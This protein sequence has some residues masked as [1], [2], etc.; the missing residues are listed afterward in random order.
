MTVCEKNLCCFECVD[1]DI[2]ENVVGDRDG[3]WDVIDISQKIL[4]NLY[5]FVLNRADRLDWPTP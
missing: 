4:L 5:C 3:E 2:V 1:Y